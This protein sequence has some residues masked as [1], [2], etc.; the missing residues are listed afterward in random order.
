MKSKKDEIINF[1]KTHVLGKVLLTDELT[2]TLEDG[3]LEGVYSD[4]IIFTGLFESE[5]GF[6][7]DM[8]VIANEKVYQLD[9]NGDR[10]SLNRD[11]NGASVF[12]YEMAE[13][14]STSDI[15]G[16]MRMISTTVKD[17]TVEALVYGIYNVKLAD[18]ELSWDECQVLYRDMTSTDGK[19][20]P[21]ALDPKAGLFFKDKKLQFEY[22][23]TCFDV[24][25]ITLEKTVSKDKLPSFI[26]KEQ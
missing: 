11:Y 10:I 24:N 9:D 6:Y 12:R 7:F 22:M 17:H 15:T 19:H 21:V 23:V 5:N 16:I 13:R 20:R 8:S 4:Q 25:P 3:K 2:Y 26:A 14:R 1:L 18:D